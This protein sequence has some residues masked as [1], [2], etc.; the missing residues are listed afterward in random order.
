MKIL[1][2]CWYGRNRSRYIADLLAKKGHD[3]DY[4]GVKQDHDEVQGKIDWSEIVVSVHPDVAAVLKESY[5]LEKVKLIELDVEDRPEKVISEGKP[6]DG[7]DWKMF[8]ERY[9]YTKLA[10]EIHEKLSL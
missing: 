2:M 3:T 7:E 9:V 6:L 1:G 8:Q 5:N 10:E 4:A